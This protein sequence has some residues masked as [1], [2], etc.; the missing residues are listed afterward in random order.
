MRVRPDVVHCLASEA[1]LCVSPRR[2]VVTVHDVIPWT[3]PGAAADAV[4]YL[5]MQRALIRH[6]GA[7]I[8]PSEVV[9]ED[10]VSVLGVPAAR[11]TAIEHGV[12]AEFSPKPME[13]DASARAAAGIGKRPYII[14]VG[15][16]HGV[17]RRKGLDVLLDAVGALEHPQRPALALVGKPGQA[18]EWARERASKAQ[19]DLILPGFV[20]D[21]QLAALY[22][23]ALAA[24]LPSRYEGFG[25]PAL[26]AMAC[27]TPAVV[28]N[29][30]ATAGVVAD[31]ALVVRAGDANGLSRA[32][33]V[34]LEDAEMHAWLRSAGPV[35]ATAFSWSRAAERTVDVYERVAAHSH[36]NRVR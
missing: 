30:G 20:D 13:D 36:R 3:A 4:A 9:V 29:A 19:I 34:L 12:A 25:L 32:L 15:S 5:R 24:V 2:Q 27:G 11:V 23:G 31:A 18:S 35:R 28:T 8:V 33:R 14:W 26:E 17:D 10:V 16:L 6:A 22:R 21:L 1:S 7:V